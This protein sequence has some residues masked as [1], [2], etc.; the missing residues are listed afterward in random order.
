MT[1]TYTS[2][3]VRRI[4]VAAFFTAALTLSIF[5]GTAFAQEGAP[6][7][8]VATVPAGDTAATVSFSVPIPPLGTIKLTYNTEALSVTISGAITQRFKIYKKVFGGEPEALE[9]TSSAFS[10]VLT[11][12]GVSS[13]AATCEGV[14][15]GDVLYF[16]REDFVPEFLE[17]TG[18][19]EEEEIIREEGEEAPVEEFALEEEFAE[20]PAEEEPSFFENVADFFGFGDEEEEEAPAEEF[21]FET[22]EGAGF[23]TDEL[24]EEVAIEEPSFFENVADFFGFGEEEEVVEEGVGE[25][26]VEFAE[27]GEEFA[28]EEVVGGGF[29][30]EGELFGAA[31]E[32]EFVFGEEGEE[33]AEEGEL[34]GE[35]FVAGEAPEG[36]EVF[37]EEGAAP[38]EEKLLPRIWR[39]VRGF[40]ETVQNKVAD[41]IIKLYVK[42]LPLAPGAAEEGAIDEGALIDESAE[43]IEEPEALNVQDAPP[44][45]TVNQAFQRFI[46]G[47]NQ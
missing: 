28:E 37:A 24:G 17:T 1:N 10:K 30:D 38:V 12:I 25:E 2:A 11:F 33:F 45:A 14:V 6:A 20:E 13:G 21:A 8:L 42:P 36:E 22:G 41:V 31:G 40:A 5:A 23:E 15:A 47:L 46:N 16:V 39:E 9:C 7:L 44:V 3:I 35:E 4:V 32:D 29:V 19:T 43:F 26:F 34:L 27:G 18:V